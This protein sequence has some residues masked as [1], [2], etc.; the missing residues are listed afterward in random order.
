MLCQIQRALEVIYAL[1]EGEQKVEDYLISPARLARMGVQVRAS[2]ELL[3]VPCADAVELA[4]YVDPA[5]LSRLP[6]LTADSPGRFLAE[7]LPSFAAAA[8]GVSHFVYLTWQAL[9]EQAVS[10]LELE[11]Q[12]EVDKFAAGVLHLW[13]RGERHGSSELRARLFDRV[14]YR[15]DLSGPEEA[16]YRFANRLARGYTSF[17]EARFVLAGRLEALL[18]ELRR[19]YRMP[20]ADKFA[21]LAQHG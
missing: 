12:A 8:E 7:L 15:A 17:L 16:R 21:W 19:T 14:G 6:E 20:A 13:K 5:V 11:A 18:A 3:V 1:S 9:R 4:L 2:E 10:L